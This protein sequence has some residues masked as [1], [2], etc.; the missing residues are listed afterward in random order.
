MSHLEPFT[1]NKRGLREKCADFARRS[2][3]CRQKVHFVRVTAATCGLYVRMGG[4]NYTF[5]VARR[6]F[7]KKKAKTS[8]KAFVHSEK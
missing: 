4:F 3:F 7:S 2:R 8:V 6:Q 5:W 1:V